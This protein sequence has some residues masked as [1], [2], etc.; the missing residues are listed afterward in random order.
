LV[1]QVGDDAGGRALRD[2]C[3]AHGID[4]RHVMLSSVH[5][6]SEYAAIIDPRRELV[7]GA[8]A[9]AAIDGLTAGMLE[10]AFGEDAAW[11]FADCNLPAP[12]LAALIERSRTGNRRLAV[13][14]VS[15]AKAARLPRDLRGIAVLFVNDDE[16]RALLG[17]TAGSSADDVANGL[18]ECGADAVVLTRGALGAVVASPE[19]TV[20][21][22]APRAAPV[23]VTGAGDALIA[24]TLY[25]LLNGEPLAGAVRTG[26][27]VAL[28]TIESPAT[29]S[30][31]LDVAAVDALRARFAVRA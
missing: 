25:G 2:D 19:G 4:V 24:G 12:V 10:A 22:P 30:D 18:R 6:T 16:A 13:D 5:P 27:L 21:V 31:T 14:G 23:D 8:S 17:G 7:I 28:L 29:V 3:A 20:E 11:T 1:T 26:T 15:I 9:T